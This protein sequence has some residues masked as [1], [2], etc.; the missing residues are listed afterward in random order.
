MSVDCQNSAFV[1]L[2]CSLYI[3]GMF[4]KPGFIAFREKMRDLYALFVL[5]LFGWNPLIH[6]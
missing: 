6:C 2:L 3:I 1:G 4:R 5:D